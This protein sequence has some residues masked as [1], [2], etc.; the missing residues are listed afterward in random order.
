[1]DKTLFALI[2]EAPFCHRGSQLVR[3][4]RINGYRVPSAIWYICNTTPTPKA[5]RASRGSRQTGRARRMP[6]AT[7][8]SVFRMQQERYS[9]GISIRLLKP[10][11]CKDT[12]RQT[13]ID[14]G[15]FTQAPPLD[16]KLQAINAWGEKENQSL[17]NCPI[18]P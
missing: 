3:T 14:V 5:L 2:K 1:M 11:L 4:Q 10:D 6:V 13:S 18:P 17:L 9:H 16:D 15:N 7:N 8:N 12:S